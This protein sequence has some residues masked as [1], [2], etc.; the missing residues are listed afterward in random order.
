MWRS[1]LLLCALFLFESVTTAQPFK[2]VT[3]LAVMHPKFPC[4]QLLVAMEPVEQPAI[5]IL[6][7][8][9]GKSFECVAKF[10]QRSKGAALFVHPFN[11]TCT[12]SGRRCFP[13]DLDFSKRKA[14]KRLIRKLQ[15]L[16][17]RYGGRLFL[18]YGLEDQYSR[19]KA[20]QVR[21]WLL[22]EFPGV[23]YVR[24]ST[25]VV[26]TPDLLEQ[27]DRLHCTEPVK[28]LSN[29]GIELPPFQLAINARKYSSECFAYFMWRGEWQGVGEKFVRP[30]DREFLFE[31]NDILL[32]RDAYVR[33]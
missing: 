12:R 10:L 2:G 30:K 7:S 29:D 33:G 24:N 1:L 4:K 31:S 28:I 20:K 6:L 27:H 19:S 8:T 17:K 22:T 11:N 23:T 16:L 18:S 14:A 9:F 13:E 25:T 26:V 32:V 21:N 5:Q 3:V 15:A